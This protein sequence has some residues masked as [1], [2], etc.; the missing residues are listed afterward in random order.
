MCTYTLGKTG[1][2]GFEHVTDYGY[3]FHE[4][5]K[6]SL[7]RKRADVV[8]LYQP[9]TESMRDIHA[10][11]VDCMVATLS[12]LKRANTQVGIN[13]MNDSTCSWLSQ[14]DLDDLNVENAYFRSFDAIVRR[15][16]DPVWHKVGPRTKQLVGDLGTLRRLL[17][18]GRSSS[19]AHLETWLIDLTDIFYLTTRSHFTSTS[20]PSCY[21][22]LSTKPVAPNSTSHLG[23]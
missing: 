9:M 20:R 22:I 1:G 12:E 10:A 5:V 23:F 18:Y 3:S 2:V 14:L 16:L 4:E 7:E 17:V 11:I 6:N 19:R 13:L 21:R 8:E 15:Q